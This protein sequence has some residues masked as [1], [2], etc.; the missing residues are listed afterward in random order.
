MA[1]METIMAVGKPPMPPSMVAMPP[2]QWV[3]GACGYGYLYSQGYG[4]S[5]AALSTALFNNGLSCGACYELRCNDDPKWCF[6]RTITVTATNFCPPNY[7]LSSDNG[8]WCNPPREHFDLAEPAF[9]QIAEYRAGHRPNSLQKV[10]NINSI[11]IITHSSY[12]QQYLAVFL[13]FACRVSCVKWAFIL[14]LGSDNQRGRCRG[15]NVGVHQGFENRVASDF[16][17]LGPKLAEQCLP[18]RPKPLFQS[19]SQ[20]WQDYYKQQCSAWWLA[21]R[22]NI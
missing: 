13:A 9:L 16:P 18:Q 10:M 1:I 2:A 19:D 22:T 14:Q 20:R 17:K 15:Y 11:Q 6:T 5:T 8:G 7:D 3:R 21:I 4:T 12:L